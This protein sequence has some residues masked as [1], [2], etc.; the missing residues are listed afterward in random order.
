M[1]ANGW[2]NLGLS[3][4]VRRAVTQQNTQQF[5]LMIYSDNMK[6][7]ITTITIH[8]TRYR[9]IMTAYHLQAH[10]Y[11]NNRKYLGGPVGLNRTQTHCQ[12]P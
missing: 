10:T 4:I 6:E 1:L 8:Q 2:L 3:L 11:H 7:I 12:G 5:D 9:I